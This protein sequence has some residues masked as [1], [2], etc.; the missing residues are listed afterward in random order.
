MVLFLLHVLRS[1]ANFAARY[2]IC[3]NQTSHEEVNP[4][5]GTINDQLSNARQLLWFE[6]EI[7]IEVIAV[8]PSRV[9]L[10]VVQV[11]PRTKP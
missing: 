6:I 9:S 4:S 10:L 11:V 7:G 8:S 3:H 2:C 5:K 1:M